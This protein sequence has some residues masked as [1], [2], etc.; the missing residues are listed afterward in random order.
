MKKLFVVLS[1]LALMTFGAFAQN[2]NTATKPAKTKTTKAAKPTD[3]AGIQQCISDKL[4]K[5]KMASDGFQVS[6]SGGV[7][8]FTGTTKVRG[9]K[10]GV[11]GIAK[12]CGAKSVTNNI[13]VESTAKT[14]TTKTKNANTTK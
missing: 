8:T 3:D 13:T 6:V 11:H 7:A 14:K 5:S 1:A 9:H 10:G 12:S 2:T 4:A